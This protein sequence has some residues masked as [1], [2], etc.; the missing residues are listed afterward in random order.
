MGN[1]WKLDFYH[2]RHTVLGD[3]FE[4]WFRFDYSKMKV[5][6][7]FGSVLINIWFKTTKTI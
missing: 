5:D 1:K 7:E 4:C 3:V 6:A 2:I